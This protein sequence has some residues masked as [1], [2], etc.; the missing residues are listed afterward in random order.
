[1]LRI[2]FYCSLVVLPLVCV[3]AFF[4]LFKPLISLEWFWCCSFYWHFIVC[5]TSHHVYVFMLLFIL[6]L[7]VYYRF[8]CECVCERVFFLSLLYSSEHSLW[9]APVVLFYSH[10]V[11]VFFFRIQQDARVS[12]V[13]VWLI[14]W[15][16]EMKEETNTT[17][18]CLRFIW[19]WPYVRNVT[20]L[21]KKIMINHHKA[22]IARQL[23]CS[24]IAFG[25]SGAWV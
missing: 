12:F 21:L 7:Q 11:F 10:L 2:F 3:F 18:C 22:I 1:M 20:Y 9:S 19:N 8:C 23:R 17:N 16:L 13:Y 24:L 15:Y 5:K 6:R 25:M 4:R 14:L